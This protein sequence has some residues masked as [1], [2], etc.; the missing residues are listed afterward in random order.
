MQRVR[1]STSSVG[2]CRHHLVWGAGRTV[3][4]QGLEACFCNRI[5]LGSGLYSLGGRLSRPLGWLR[6]NLRISAEVGPSSAKVGPSSNKTWAVLST[7]FGP[8]PGKVRPILS[9][10][11]PYLV[12]H[13]GYQLPN[14]IHNWS[15]FS[16]G[17]VNLAQTAAK[18]CTPSSTQFGV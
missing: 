5:R 7:K 18:S 13:R 2:R 4:L 8:N 1:Q 14:S 3:V 11:R 10:V 15:G 16:P 6:P 17:V 9:R 12:A